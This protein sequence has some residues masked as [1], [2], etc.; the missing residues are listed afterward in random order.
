MKSDCAASPGD[1][2]RA[3]NTVGEQGWGV[4]QE[5]KAEGILV[6]Y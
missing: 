4:D 6:K 1:P 5:E 3:Q 2:P